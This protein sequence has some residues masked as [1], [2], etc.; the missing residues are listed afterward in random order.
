M[1]K[2][3]VLDLD[4]PG[5]TSGYDSYRMV[6]MVW[7]IPYK[8]KSP[9]KNENEHNKAVLFLTPLKSCENAVSEPSENIETQTSSDNEEISWCG[10][11]WKLFIFG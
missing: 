1:F 10:L 6:H 9:T 8:P 7:P 2:T 4:F 11:C 3:G 5:F